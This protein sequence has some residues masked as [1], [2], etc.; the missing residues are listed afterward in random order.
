MYT[1]YYDV[2]PPPSQ[3]RWGCHIHVLKKDGDSTSTFLRY[4]GH[5]ATLWHNIF[6]AILYYT[7]LQT[8]IV[9]YIMMCITYAY[10]CVDMPPPPSLSEMGMSP[11][12]HIVCCILYQ[13]ILYCTLLLKRGYYGIVWV[14]YAILYYMALQTN[15][16]I[17]IIWS[18]ICVCHIHF[19]KWDGD[20]TFARY[21]MLCAILYYIMLD[22]VYI[23]YIFT[24]IV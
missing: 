12:P 6:Y 23:L 7:A 8:N 22:R 15:R 17:Y 1:Y 2:P 19:L 14:Y 24:H 10:I 4:M 5:Y 3:V 21:C 13:T 18:S 16:M 11:S 20:A 9:I